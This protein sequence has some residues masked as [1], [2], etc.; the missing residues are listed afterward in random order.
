MEN[1]FHFELTEGLQVG[2]AAARFREDV[3]FLVRQLADGL[4]AAGVDAK[5]VD[6]IVVRGARGAGARCVRGAQCAMRGA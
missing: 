6:H 3:A 4:G 2:A 1:L 5:D